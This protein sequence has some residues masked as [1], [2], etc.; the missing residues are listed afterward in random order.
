MVRRTDVA[1]LLLGLGAGAPVVVDMKGA[2]EATKSSSGKQYLSG[3]HSS[4]W[5]R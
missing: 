3:M 4:D 1:S 2:I 5:R